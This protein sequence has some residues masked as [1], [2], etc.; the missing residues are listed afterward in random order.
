MLGRRHPSSGGANSPEGRTHLYR[1]S[2][3]AVEGGC[4]P[5]ADHGV[6]SRSSTVRTSRGTHPT[7][8]RER[9]GKRATG[10]GSGA[11][12]GFRA[13]QG[14][15]SPGQRRP[16]QAWGRLPWPA[17]RCLT[18]GE[19][20]AETLG[21][22]SASVLGHLPRTFRRR[23]W[24]SGVTVAGTVAAYCPRNTGRM[25]SSGQDGGSGDIGDTGS[26][27]AINARSSLLRSRAGRRPR[28]R[29]HAGAEHWA[30][31]RTRRSIRLLAGQ[32]SASALDGPS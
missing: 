14:N 17:V 12:T 6:R 2:P 8:R 4:C 19:K 18:R 16:G 11:P 10:L 29:R 26:P 15:G 22:V 13:L 1:S 23:T 5:T 20:I 7:R 31:A 24:A 9:I 25:P 21:G 27:P 32:G 30:S 28:D 3:M